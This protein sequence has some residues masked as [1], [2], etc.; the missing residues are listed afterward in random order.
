MSG[1]K[2]VTSKIPLIFRDT[3]VTSGLAI[4]TVTAIGNATQLGKIGKSLESITEEKTPLEKQINSF[5]K[6]MVAIGAIIFSFDNPVISHFSI[7]VIGASIVLL[8]LEIIK[9]SKNEIQE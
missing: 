2:D 4:A 5:V 6:K 9:Y 3:S 1:Y 7:S 8:T